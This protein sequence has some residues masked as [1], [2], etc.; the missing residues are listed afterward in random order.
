MTNRDAFISR[1]TKTLEPGY[2]LYDFPTK[3]FAESVDQ[4]VRESIAEDRQ[5]NSVVAMTVQDNSS[6]GAGWTLSLLDYHG[7]FVCHLA[8]NCTYE[9]ALH[10]LERMTAFFKER[11]LRVKHVQ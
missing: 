4:L 3:E 2:D 9:W 7:R 1:W 8:A 10:E 6:D 11:G 5:S